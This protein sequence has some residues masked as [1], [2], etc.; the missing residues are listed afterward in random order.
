MSIPI[1]LYPNITANTPY[2]L[3]SDV[4]NLIG[5]TEFYPNLSAEQVLS[6]IAQQQRKIDRLTNKKFS[7][8]RTKLQ[9]DG[10]SQNSMVLKDCPLITINEIDIWMTLPLNATRVCNDWDFIVDRHNGIISFP[11]IINQPMFGPFGFQFFPGRGNIN[12]DVT[13]GYTQEVYGESPT[14]SDNIHYVLTN[15]TGVMNSVANVYGST[16]PPS[17]YPVVYLNGTPLVNTTFVQDSNSIWQVATNN[18]FYTINKGSAGIT[19]LTFNN[20]VSGI[21][22]VD[23]S[24]WLV[25]QDINEACAKMTAIALLMAAG[26]S[27]QDEDVWSAA[28]TLQAQ[29]SKNTYTSGPWGKAIELWKQEIAEVINNNKSILSPYLSSYNGNIM[30]SGW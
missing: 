29:T 10:N 4:N 20:A 27:L 8:Y 23:Y 3:P 15:P 22:T 9:Y 6:A 28:D 21:I 24:F 13:Y 5:S 26:T 19:G 1:S 11:L 30:G 25:P 18:L 17:F 2:C 12:I 7:P 14:T 16:S